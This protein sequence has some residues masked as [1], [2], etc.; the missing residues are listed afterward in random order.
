MVNK[1]YLN[2]IKHLRNNARTPLTSISKITH[3]PVSTLHDRLKLTEDKYINKHT[4]LLDFQKLG[5]ALR[6][7]VLVNST[8]VIKL[9]DFIRENPKINSA[10]NL[11][12]DYN[13]LL[14]CIF[15]DMLDFN[16]FIEDLS[17]LPISSKQVYFVYEDIK[18]EAFLA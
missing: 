3:T 10:Y 16:N 2:L 8:A 15:Q 13:F 4:S 18:R 1:K 7:K 17:L 11:Q 6:A 12:G 14:D 9:K 5:Y